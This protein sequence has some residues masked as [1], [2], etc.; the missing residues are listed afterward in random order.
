MKRIFNK[1]VRSIVFVLVLLA[2]GV[3][4]A[5]S[6]ALASTRQI[7]QDSADCE[8]DASMIHI[9]EN[10]DDDL[11]APIATAAND[12]AMVNRMLQSKGP[13]NKTLMP[14]CLERQENT[15]T[16]VPS[17]LR[18][19]IKLL[20]YATVEDAVTPLIANEQKTYLS[21]KSPPKKADILSSVIKI[22]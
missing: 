12:C 6:I 8:K 10:C 22:E 9:L 21:S 20:E 17:E 7:K 2:F 16:I 18:E 14:C 5:E 3:F 4:F 1:N 11:A 19:R 15:A 13:V